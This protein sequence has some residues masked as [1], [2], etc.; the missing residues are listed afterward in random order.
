MNKRRSARQATAHRRF[1]T[2][3][4][5][6]ICRLGVAAALCSVSVA[7]QA[8]TVSNLDTVEHRV[9]FEAVQGS[10]VTRF[11]APGETV[12]VMQPS[13]AVYLEGQKGSPVYAYPNDVLAIWPE[14]KLHLQMR[15]K[16]GGIAF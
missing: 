6:L 14:G 5:A 2:K 1:A 11:V 9:V 12:R 3:M 7:A 4:R 8:L 13:G 15:R 10:K 16:L